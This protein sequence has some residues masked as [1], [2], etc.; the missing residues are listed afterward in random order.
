MK[1]NILGTEK[2]S[3]LLVKFMIPA[4]VSMIIAGAQTIIDGMFLGNYV[5]PNAMASVNIVQPF[6]Q[7]IIGCSMIISVGSLSFIGRSLGDRN[8]EEAQN[9]FKTSFILIIIS[10]IIISILGIFFSERIAFILGANQVLLNGVASYVKIISMFAPLI[11][12]MFLFGF[13]NRVVGRPD[14]Y[15]KGMI[16]SV[17]CNIILDFLLIK[18]LGLGVSGAAIATGLA[19]V[20][21]FFVVIKPMIDKN[22]IVN[23]FKGKFD[24]SVIV[25]VVYNGSSEGVTAIAIA[26]T[27]YVF[28]MAFM[29]IAGAAGVAAF[30]TINYI[31]EFGVLIMFGISDGIGPIIS[32]NHGYKD[33]DRVKETLNLALKINLIVGAILFLIL[34]VFGKELVSMFAK[35][36]EE[37]LKLAIDGSKIYAF[38][39]LICGFNII[40][41]GYFT[42]IGDARASIVIAASRG[43]VFIILGIIILP[44]LIGISGV[45]LTIPFA[46]IVTIIISMY[47]TKISS[48]NLEIEM[49]TQ[50]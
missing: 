46:E 24:K 35:G 41:S 3:K 1:E 19:Y 45:W 30:T 31:G 39:F 8:D 49:I 42:S 15:L 5:G 23:V 50:Q 2:I 21:A 22:N 14:L 16:L 33:K 7:V 20:V 10:T 27:A 26:T 38:S 43:I 11:G 34:F 48:K 44:N 4:I 28:N 32:Y 47:L 17:I 37:V 25:P 36:N 18:K 9:I 6:M 40:K 29:Q 13:I 12:L